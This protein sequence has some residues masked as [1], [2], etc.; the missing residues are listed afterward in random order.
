MSILG[1]RRLTVFLATTVSLVA[2][3]SAIPPASASGP[4]VAYRLRHDFSLVPGLPGHGKTEPTS[5][6]NSPDGEGYLCRIV[7]GYEDTGDK[8]NFLVRR[9][10]AL[11]DG[12]DSTFGNALVARDGIV[13]E[14]C[15]QWRTGDWFCDYKTRNQVSREHYESKGYVARTFWKWKDYIKSQAGCAGAI[16]GLWAGLKGKGFLFFLDECNNG[17]L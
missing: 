17:P 13:Y 11:D 4:S 12:H 7:A 1:R 14:G 10:D 16:S 15:A 5:C 8:R 3:P 9:Q 2:L 6:Y